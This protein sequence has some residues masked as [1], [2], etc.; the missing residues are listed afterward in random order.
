MKFDYTPKIQKIEDILN[1]FVPELQSNENDYSWQNLN[2]SNLPAGVETKHF[3]QLILPCR[4]LM[5]LGG[6]RWRPVFMVLCSEL[7]KNEEVELA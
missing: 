3:N 6:K 1:N 5:K 4:N 7:I 2:F